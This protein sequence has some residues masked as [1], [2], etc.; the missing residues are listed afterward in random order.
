MFV[1]ILATPMKVILLARNLTDGYYMVTKHNIFLSFKTTTLENTNMVVFD[2]TITAQYSHT[3]YV[4]GKVVRT[5]SVQSWLNH[6][7]DQIIKNVRYL[8]ATIYL[9]KAFVDL[10][11]VHADWTGIFKRFYREGLRI[12]HIHS[13]LQ[14][15][16]STFE[17]S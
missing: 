11:E 7:V 16:I 12:I 4:R 14:R 10:K 13:K 17:I 8:P 5:T 6:W 2:L 9:C 3:P 15:W 1:R